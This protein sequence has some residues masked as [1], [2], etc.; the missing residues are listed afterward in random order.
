MTTHFSDLA[1]LFVE[2]GHLEDVVLGAAMLRKHQ[3]VICIYVHIH[4]V[5]RDNFGILNDLLLGDN[6]DTNVLIIESELVLTLQYRPIAE[7]VHFIVALES[8]FV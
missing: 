7:A 5:R 6:L 4:V 2:L 3:V 1:R 8:A